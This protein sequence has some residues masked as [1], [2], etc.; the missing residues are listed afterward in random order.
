MR[1]AARPLIVVTV[2]DAAND[3]ENLQCLS[4]SLNSSKGDREPHQWGKTKYGRS[5]SAD[6]RC[7]VVEQWRKVK[8][9]Y[10]M[11]ADT[12]ELVYLQKQLAG[13]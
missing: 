2:A 9:K 4:R 7:A 12:D 13:C 10:R 11:T 6:E 5:L 8:V 3:T 1:L